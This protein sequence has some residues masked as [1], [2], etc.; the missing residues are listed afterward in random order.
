MKFGFAILLIFLS[1]IWL[2]A[3]QP[4]SPA[5]SD[6]AEID[7]LVT[8]LTE[9]VQQ[10]PTIF[11]PT[12]RLDEEERQALKTA[13]NHGTQLLEKTPNVEQRYWAAEFLVRA[14]LTL[15]RVQPPS[16]LTELRKLEDLVVILG[17]KQE[18]VP[19]VQTAKYQI[20]THSI[21]LLT[22]PGDDLP[23]PYRVKESVK[24]YVVENPKNLDLAKLLINAAIQNASMDRQFAVETLK[25]IAELYGNSEFLDDREY[26]GKLQAMLKRFELLGNPVPF[27]GVDLAGKK[28]SSTDF[29]NKV[30]LID[31]W[32]TWCTPCVSALPEM[33][34]LHDLYNKRGFEIVGVSVDDKKDDLAKFLEERKLPWKILSDTVTEEKGGT[35]LAKHFGV[36]QY[37]TLMLV[38]R[39][40]KL[41]ATDFDMKTLEKL[42]IRQFNSNTA[43]SRPTAMLQPLERTPIIPSLL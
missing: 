38:G 19:I 1:S 34:R 23:N 32:A 20:L 11:G 2:Y 12:A 25:E 7:R 10:Y 41:I 21:L 40:G 28:I 43:R 26:L 37:P 31:F 6:P 24:Q 33:K 17:E 4:V 39:D 18:K 13:I 9:F 22:K 42:L 16:T 14:K 27:S 29:K 15:A 30:V 35:R 5:V 3:A 8:A 36:S